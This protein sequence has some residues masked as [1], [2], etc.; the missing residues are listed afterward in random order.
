MDESRKISDKVENFTH[1]NFRKVFIL[2]NILSSSLHLYR[3]YIHQ[4]RVLNSREIAAWSS[5]YSPA[6]SGG[7]VFIAMLFFV[8]G[9]S[10]ER[11]DTLKCSVR[12]RARADAQRK[13]IIRVKSQAAYFNLYFNP[14]SPV[15]SCTRGTV[16]RVQ[17][18][19]GPARLT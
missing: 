18:F 10:W 17:S 7:E 8:D 15:L 2:F 13:K 5:A 12:S 9:I 6:L 11:E 16:T 19:Y 14:L 1:D 3:L 4:G